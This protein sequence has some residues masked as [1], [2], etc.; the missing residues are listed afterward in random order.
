MGSPKYLNKQALSENYYSN[1]TDIWSLTCTLFNLTT[2][3]DFVLPAGF[4]NT[5]KNCLEVIEKGFPTNR[6]DGTCQ[7]QKLSERIQQCKYGNILFQLL[8]DVPRKA[9]VPAMVLESDSFKRLER[10]C[11][12]SV[13]INF[14]GNMNNCYK[15]GLA[16]MII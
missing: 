14:D 4:E 8:D 11:V 7:R 16:T 9:N 1:Q 12:R 10:E 3:N 5:E 6:T 13:V 2:G 15:L